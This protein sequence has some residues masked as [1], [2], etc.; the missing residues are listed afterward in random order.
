MRQP[1]AWQL[2]GEPLIFSTENRLLDG[3][4]RMAA[5][6]QAGVS[7]RFLVVRGIAISAQPT[8][9]LALT[10]NAADILASN[11]ETNVYTLASALR[12]LW[13]HEHQCVMTPR[14]S[15]ATQDT[16]EILT[17]YPGLPSSLSWGSSTRKLLPIAA[18]ASFHYLAHQRDPSTA[19]H[20]F[21]WL[22]TGTDLAAGHPIHD[23]R[24]K[25]IGAKSR[26]PKTKTWTYLYWC[27]LC[28]NAL[29][30]G[31]TAPQLAWQPMLE[32]SRFPQVV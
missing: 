7:L 1:G 25:L 9:G 16:L 31:K 27:V 20:V 10:R 6:V 17:R 4:N 26:T 19:K 23:L 12:L 11:Q 8:L 18:G 28:W 14:R 15:F 3:Q 2:N 13:G 30:T 24:E 5:L 21:Q 29:R 22:K 32:P